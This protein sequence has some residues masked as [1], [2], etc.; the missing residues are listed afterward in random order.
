MPTIRAAVALLLFMSS[1]ICAA[2]QPEGRRA[3]ASSEK[4]PLADGWAIRSSCETQATSDAISR[5]GFHEEGWLA[6]RVPSTVMAA[7]VTAGKFEDPFFGT[8]LRK[9]PGMDYPQKELYVNLPVTATSPYKCSWWYRKDF[10]V[11]AVWTKKV[12]IH[13]NGINY[14]GN[15]WVNGKQVATDQDIRGTYRTYDFDITPYIQRGKK[16]AVAV[17]TFIQTETDL[18]INFVDWQPT[19]A[20]KNMGLWRDVYLA[21]S[22][23]VTLRNPAVLTHFTDDDLSAAE[24]T[25]IADVENHSDN[26][27]ES[28]VRGNIVAVKFEQK[29]ALG[30]K[31]KK[32]VR[33]EPSQFAQLRIAKPGVWWPYQYGKPQLHNLKLT[34]AIGPSVSDEKSIRFGIREVDG[35]LNEKGFLQFRVNRKN[36]LI[37][38]GGWGVD[39]FYREPKERLEKEFQYVKAMNLNTVRLEGKLGSDEIFNIADEMGVMI[40]AGWCCCDHWEHWDKW[41]KGDLAIANA[42]LQSQISRLRAHPSVFVWLNG[43]DGPPPA[44]V[45]SAYIA[46]LKER[47]WQNPFISSASQKATTVTGPSGVKMTGPYDYVPPEYWYID[48]QK[49][50]GAY[51]FNT[52]T[53]PGPAI[54]SPA[55]VKRTLPKE[56]WWPQDDAWRFHGGLGSFQQYGNFNTG[57]NSQYGEAKDLDEYTRKA[58]WM[59]YDGERAMFEAYSANKY[60]STGVIQWMLNN[61]WPSFIWHLYDYYLVPGGGYFG[62]KKANEPLHILYRFDD[63]NVAVVNSELNGRERLEASAR[64]FDLK[65]KEVFTKK[66]PV[67]VGA[68]A[69]ATLFAIPAEAGPHFLKLELKDKAGKTVSDNFYVVTDKLAEFDWA[70][71]TYVFTPSLSFADYRDLNQ[72][73]KGTVSTKIQWVDAKRATVTLVNTGKTVAFMV[74]ARLVKPRTDEELAPVLWSDNFVSLLP[75]ESRMLK[76]ELLSGNKETEIHVDGWNVALSKVKATTSLEKK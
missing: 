2:A 9:I 70:K 75:G 49:E 69:V 39:M 64:L 7:Q 29:V 58:Q 74:H 26:P 63:R 61:G 15:L 54:P 20:D 32:T 14:R 18:G 68:D 8:N 22:G 55:E 4:L 11:P 6:T 45:E 34:A 56:S 59:A 5:A 50:G 76:V 33:F 36:I 60:T 52:E 62:T 23:T 35:K 13:F 24:L 12:W 48:K 65:G 1:L 44:E 3:A 31:E 40:M 17:E 21:E 73:E 41:A 28:V 16:N 10:E 72:L 19:A 42:S 47:D 27:V 38:G 25:V 37:R 30:P 67:T 51:G 71:T 46:T 53:S 57:M 43:S 66:A